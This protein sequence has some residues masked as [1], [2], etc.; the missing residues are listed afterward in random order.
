MP[1]AFLLS[2]LWPKRKSKILFLKPIKNGLLA[3]EQTETP[4]YVRHNFRFAFNVKSN[5]II[6]NITTRVNRDPFS[7]I[8]C[9]YETGSYILLG[10][11]YADL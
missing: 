5:L 1:S 7:A 3:P 2:G 11:M 9:F 4:A 6:S 8:K 10:L